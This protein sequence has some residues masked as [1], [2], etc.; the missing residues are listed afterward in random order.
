MHQQDPRRNAREGTFVLVGG[1]NEVQ[2]LNNPEKHH[3]QSWA[4]ENR[5]NERAAL[6]RRDDQS[7]REQTRLIEIFQ[8]KG[9][10]LY[11]KSH[12]GD[13]QDYPGTRGKKEGRWR[14]GRLLI[15]RGDR[16]HRRREERVIRG[17]AIYPSSWPNCASPEDW[18]D[19]LLNFVINEYPFKW[20]R[21]ILWAPCCII[22]NLRICILRSGFWDFTILQFWNF[23]ILEK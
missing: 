11:Y 14:I 12:A 10:A 18:G 19:K 1:W 5:Q 4:Q 23:G 6:V 9:R 13:W 8:R 20:L 17:A 3:R 22:W 21:C 2:G 16:G 15:W 7:F